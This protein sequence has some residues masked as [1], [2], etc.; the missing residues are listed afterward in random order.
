ME[1]A[2][3]LSGVAFEDG[4]TVVA[5]AAR[6]P[7]A[8]GGHFSV[9]YIAEHKDGRR[10]FLKALDYTAA[11][12]HPNTAEV[13]QAMTR[14][15]IFE[16]EL[17]EK[18]AS[19]S[20]VARAIG[21][22]S[23]NLTEDP[24]KKVEYLIFEL[25]DE[26][27]RSHLDDA[28][29]LDLVFMMRTLHQVA[30]G[31]S[32]LHRAEIAHQDLK[33]SNVLIFDSGKSSKICD[34]GRAWDMNAS[35]PYDS[36]PVAGDGA[37]APVDAAYG[38]TSTDHHVRRY[39]C[40]L[41]HL[42]S[43]I[44][45]LFTRVQTNALLFAHL[46]P[47]HRSFSWGGTYKEVLPYIQAAFELALNDFANTVPEILRAELREAVEQLCNPDPSRRGHPKGSSTT[48]YSLE[49]YISLFDLLARRAEIQ[50]Y[51]AKVLQGA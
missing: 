37:H 12:K 41:Y 22:G 28:A 4:W 29:A 20:R 51:R 39:G 43:L 24:F 34:L 5:E 1:P 8:T 11:F 40:D 16:K 26:D 21:S 46:A 27:I 14:A 36:L 15:F 10:G 44:V 30:L 7:N 32:Q 23:I 50:L 6:K 49:R 42:G 47:Q 17:C 25:A 45:F 19:F 48:R 38:V 3:Q 2:R 31:L 13:I 33:P 35:S 9:G 18:C